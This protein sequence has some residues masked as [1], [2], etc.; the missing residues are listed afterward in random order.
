MKV[1]GEAETL[2][3]LSC[4]F[5]LLMSLSLILNGNLPRGEECLIGFLG[6][7]GD[8]SSGYTGG[9]CAG[10]DRPHSSEGGLGPRDVCILWVSLVPRRL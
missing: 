3:V 6:G 10:V 5:K 8:N 2:L 1:L 4:N 7:G 9:G